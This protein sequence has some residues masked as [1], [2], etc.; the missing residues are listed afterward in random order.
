MSERRAAPGAQP[1]GQKLLKPPH[2][3]GIHRQPSLLFSK[4]QRK[5]I[6]VE[7]LTQP[8][9]KSGK[10][11]TPVVKDDCPTWAAEM[12]VKIQ[13]LEIR[14]GNIRETVAQ[15]TSV[16]YDELVKRAEAEEEYRHTDSE[17][18]EALFGKTCRGL[19]EAGFDCA[20]IAAFANSR[21]GAGGRLPYC[22]AD[23]VGESIK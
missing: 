7:E 13:S 8:D 12:F 6:L 2:F 16:E 15:W 22:S 21:I 11:A 9:V 1:L 19:L 3:W 14:L 5:E 4:A 23:E 10:S 20:Q 18:V 17:M